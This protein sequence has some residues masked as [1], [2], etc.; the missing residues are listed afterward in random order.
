MASIG[1]AV[2][3]SG[4]ECAPEADLIRFNIVSASDYRARTGPDPDGSG[5]ERLTLLRQAG[6]LAVWPRRECVARLSLLRRG[7]ALQGPRVP[8]VFHVHGHVCVRGIH[9]RREQ[10]T[11]RIVVRSLPYLSF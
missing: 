3:M 2:P 7:V 4:T 6:L 11:G 9:G 10:W 5:Q 1:P 8:K